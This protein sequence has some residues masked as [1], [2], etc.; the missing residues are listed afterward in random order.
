MC[1]RNSIRGESPYIH[2]HFNIALPVAGKLSF[3]MKTV[4]LHIDWLYSI[5]LQIMLSIIP[6]SNKKLIATFW[7]V[8]GVVNFYRLNRYVDNDTSS[9]HS[10]LIQDWSKK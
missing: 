7:Y 1:E 9:C 2:Q 8:T 4:E 10:I 6:C 5:L 3:L